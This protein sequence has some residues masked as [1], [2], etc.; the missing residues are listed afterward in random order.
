LQPQQVRIAYL[1]QQ[2]QRLSL[3][4]MRQVRALS[5][6]AAKVKCES[7]LQQLSVYQDFEIQFQLAPL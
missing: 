3:F 1:P 7:A 5:S 2:I 4:A 6:I